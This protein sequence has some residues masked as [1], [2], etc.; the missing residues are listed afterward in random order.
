[1]LLYQV[2]NNSMC[3][4]TT[5]IKIFNI[6]NVHHKVLLLSGFETI[7]H[8]QGEKIVVVVVVVVVVCCVYILSEVLMRSR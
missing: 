3:I 1:M 7:C 5:I 8:F 6:K 4:F 2:K